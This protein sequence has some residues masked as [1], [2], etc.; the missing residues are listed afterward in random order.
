MRYCVIIMIFILSCGGHKTE[1]SNI[2]EEL[3]K[4][5]KALSSIPTD[6][7]I[8]SGGSLEYLDSQ[9][10]G[11][12]SQIQSVSNEV[13]SIEIYSITVIILFPYMK[14]Y[15]AFCKEIIFRLSG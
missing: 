8:S 10:D 12:Q 1:I 14:I 5:K 4:L 3:T 13:K 9:L 2:K 6:G 15:I 7:S 11:I